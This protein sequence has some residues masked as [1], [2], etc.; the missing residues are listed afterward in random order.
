MRNSFREGTI[1]EHWKPI[2]V[3]EWFGPRFRKFINNDVIW[4]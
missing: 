2:E 4:P 1:K 3:S